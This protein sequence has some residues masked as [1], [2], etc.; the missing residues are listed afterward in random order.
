MHRGIRYIQKRIKISEVD[1]DIILYRVAV[2]W[3]YSK[4]IGTAY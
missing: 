3:Q 4:E 1:I 2:G